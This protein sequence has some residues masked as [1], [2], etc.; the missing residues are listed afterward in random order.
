M[1]YNFDEKTI[2]KEVDEVLDH[3]IASYEA[4]DRALLDMDRIA[5]RL[6]GLPGDAAS[7][8]ERIGQTENWME[9]PYFIMPTLKFPHISR[10]IHGQ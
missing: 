1:A 6:P 9:L 8:L 3:L 10:M 2:I 5:E 7:W 4:L